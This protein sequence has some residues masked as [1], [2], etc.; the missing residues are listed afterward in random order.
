MYIILVDLHTIAAIN[1]KENYENISIGFKDAI[2][3]INNLIRVPVL[4]VNEE[5]YELEFF[6]VADYKVHI[7]TYIASYITSYMYTCM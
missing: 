3:S 4:I 5:M 2:D 1:A 7:A 6:F